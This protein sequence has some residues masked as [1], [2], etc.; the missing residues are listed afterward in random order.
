MAAEAAAAPRANQGPRVACHVIVCQM[1]WI[2]DPIEGSLYAPHSLQPLETTP[3]SM[4]TSREMSTPTTWSGPSTQRGRAAATI[5]AEALAAATSGAPQR[6]SMWRIFRTA[7]RYERRARGAPPRLL[8]SGSSTGQMF[9]HTAAARDA[10]RRLG[11]TTGCSSYSLTSQRALLTCTLPEYVACRQS[12]HVRGTTS[13]TAA[14]L[15]SGRG[16]AAGSATSRGV[17]S[18]PTRFFPHHSTSL[19]TPRTY[20]H[21]HL[22]PPRR[23]SLCPPQPTR[24]CH[25]FP[26]CP[27]TSRP[28]KT[29]LLSKPCYGRGGSPPGALGHVAKAQPP[30][31]PPPPPPY[32]FHMASSPRST[33]CPSTPRRNH[34]PLL[35]VPRPQFGPARLPSSPTPRLYPPLCGSRCPRTAPRYWVPRHRGSRS[36]ATT[37]RIAR[38]ST[39]PRSWTC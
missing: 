34:S 20:S 15:P 5:L 26:S 33:R 13:W 4:T 9:A 29:C 22:R 32:S 18:T 2:L 10:P 19:P 23:L 3:T 1:T 37:L 14:F 31:T 39:P 35:R 38:D 27:T 36:R 24:P 17:V 11:V 6:L 8:G 30:P 25:F 28:S 21:V 16:T 7:A 12:Q